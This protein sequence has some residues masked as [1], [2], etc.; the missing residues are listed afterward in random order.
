MRYRTCHQGCAAVLRF[1]LG[2][3]NHLRTYRRSDSRI[4]FEFMDPEDKAAEIARTFFE[5]EG[6]AVSNARELLACDRAVRLTVGDAIERGE[7][8][9]E[10]TKN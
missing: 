1:V 4:S 6:I 8:R 9:S 7:W 3:E 2:D 5:P 10:E